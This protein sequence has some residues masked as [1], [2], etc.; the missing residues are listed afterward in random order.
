VL[1]QA[2]MQLI[3]AHLISCTIF[4]H[5]QHELGTGEANEH[6]LKHLPLVEIHDRTN[7]EARMEP[8]TIIG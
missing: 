2:P 8:L 1:L 4:E 7:H 5:R 6:T 3:D